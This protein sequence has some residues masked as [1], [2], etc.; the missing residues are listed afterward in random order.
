METKKVV[1]GLFGIGI[2]VGVSWYAWHENKKTSAP[3]AGSTG[4]PGPAGEPGIPAGKPAAE[5]GTSNTKPGTTKGAIK[6]PV[7]KPVA[8][9][10]VTKG[11]TIYKNIE[12]IVKQKGDAGL[13]G[14]NLIAKGNSGGI[15][16]TTLKKIGT[17]KE[18]DVLGEAFKSIQTENG[19]LLKYQTPAGEYRIVAAAAVDGIYK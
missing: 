19:L 17:T 9:A 3:A 4:A 5:L 12:A 14:L 16:T 10:S 6:S 8:P 1:L 18:G 11:T 2:I 7:D 13:H 15:Y